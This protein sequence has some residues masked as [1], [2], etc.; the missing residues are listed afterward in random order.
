[1]DTPWTPGPWTVGKTE[2]G[3]W[4]IHGPKGTP[5]VALAKRNFPYTQDDANAR[6]IAASPMLAELLETWLGWADE[7]TIYHWPATADPK[8]QTPWQQARALLS[9][10]RGEE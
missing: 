6:L 1:M 2:T 5:P 4:V 3:G 10:V 9:R 7:K 8:A